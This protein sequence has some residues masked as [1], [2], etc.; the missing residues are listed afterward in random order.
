MKCLLL[1]M[2]LAFGGCATT[3]PSPPSV[4]APA[5]AVGTRAA[6]DGETLR[7]APPSGWMKTGGTDTGVLSLAEYMPAAELRADPTAAQGNWREKITFERLE[8]QPVPDP[9]GFLDGLRIDHVQG[10]PDGGYSPVSAAEE[11]G[12]P[13]AVAL[14]DC[15]KLGVTEAG[16]VTMIK[17]MQGDEAF[18]TITRSIRVAPWQRASAADGAKPSPETHPSGIDPS[19]IGG[20]SV[21]MRAISL[22]NADDPQHPCSSAPES[23]GAQD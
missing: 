16:Q 19:V 6:P 17:V 10:C 4:P 18:Y 9:L 21:W 3:L 22:C 12:Y 14:V 5:S 2:V 20:F 13:A 15:P 8:G 23:P 1:P 7:A 11:N